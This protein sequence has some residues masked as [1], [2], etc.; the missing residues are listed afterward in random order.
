MGF[1][2]D[3]AQRHVH[4]GTSSCR[5]V[6]KFSHTSSF[7]QSAEYK[8]KGALGRGQQLPIT[9]L[10]LDKIGLMLTEL[11]LESLGHL[12]RVIAHGLDVQTQINR[13]KVLEGIEA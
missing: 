4:G 3:V 12:Q 8:C 13:Q 2:L 10:T 6:P 5:L 1:K 9:G 7:R 11:R